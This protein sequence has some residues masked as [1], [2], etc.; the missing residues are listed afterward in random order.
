MK[1]LPKQYIPKE[2][3]DKIYDIWNTSGYFN[4]D[5]LTYK[6]NAP[7]Y[8][9]VMPPPNVTGT[10]HMGHAGMLA[11]EDILIRY[12]RMK[13][14]RTL[15]LPGTDHAAIAT[16]TKVEKIIKEEGFTRHSLGRDHFLKRVN[17]FAQESHDTIAKQIK[18]MG[19]SCDWSREAF[20]LDETRNKAVN[21]VFKIMYEDGLIYRGERIVNWCPRCHSTLA[22]DEVEHK[23]QQAKLYT[24][25]Y[26]KDFPIAI[27]TTR[28]ETKIGDTAIAVNPKDNRY[29]KFIGKTITVNFI[30]VDLNIK[31]IADHNIDMDFGTGALGVTPAHSVADWQMAEKNDLNII[32][33][34]DEDGKIHNDFGDFSGKTA[35]EAR[36][37]IIQ[38]IKNANL[39]EKEEEIENALSLCYRCD[40]PIEPLP[41]LQWFINV[42]QKSEKLGSKTIKEISVQAVKSGVFG[43]KKI[44]IIPQRFEKNY[45]H[46]MNDLRDWCISRQIWY[47]HRIPVWYC[48]CGEIIVDIAVPD[49]CPKCASTDLTQD[50]DTLDT[51]FS[52]GLWTFSTLASSPDQIQIKDNKLFI[53]SVDFAHF[54]PTA[55]L[56]TGYDI[57]FFWV[58]RMI[59]MTTYAVEDIPFRDVY[60]HGLV[61]DEKGK[62][63]SK[64]KGNVIDP[65]DMIN[66]YGTDATRLSLIS[67][68]TPGNDLKLSEEKIKGHRNFV[69]KLWNI[70]RFILQ[71]TESID[72]EL[73]SI[74][75]KDLTVFDKMILEKMR[76]LISMI[77]DDIEK[78]QF[79]HAAEKLQQFTWHDLADWYLEV[80]KFENNKKE[81]NAILHMILEDLLILW[82]PF[83]PFVTE[84]IWQNMKKET[85]LLITSLP[86][87][88]KY[89]SLVGQNITAQTHVAVIQEIITT[90]RNM[91][92]EYTNDAK[93][94][95]IMIDESQ[96]SSGSEDLIISHEDLIKQMRTGVNK[97]KF[98]TSKKEIPNSVITSTTS[99]GVTIIISLAN[100]V[101]TAAEKTKKQK[102]SEE[103]EKYIKTLENKLSNTSFKTNAPAD[104][105]AKEKEKLENA[106]NKMRELRTYINKINQ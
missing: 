12:Y 93:N 26:A 54:H 49:A 4:P 104:I 47:G 57:L 28:P 56:E 2:T 17:S 6:E 87:D 72:T 15:W 77:T 84:E 101:D 58:A 86:D 9:I 11:Y 78:Y 63:M 64:S 29:K 65:L 70:S 42:N 40:T 25:K 30:G 16:Q 36:K 10:L 7:S 19:S 100:L 8:C 67:G 37:L 71:K 20:T 48:V 23:N 90:V 61:L 82:H 81:K 1:E 50:S 94:V 35:Q 89:Q 97:I 69:N 34:I 85:P 68:S 102:E 95:S 22:D 13:G 92:K 96:R 66:A 31:I 32:K 55:V 38:K 41:S 53:D 59:I 60:L 5:H 3:E 52:S 27:A 75:S 46:W 105:V 24:F 39:L 73:I 83:I 14:Y 98:I 51:W 21:A 99:H 103:L 88:K 76:D 80:A 43:K 33:V 44:N 62:K 91:T 18:K 106:K 45:F 79:S 74:D